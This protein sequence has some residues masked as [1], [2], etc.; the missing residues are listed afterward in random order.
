[1][2]P[3]VVISLQGPLNESDSVFAIVGK[4]E[5]TAWRTSMRACSLSTSPH[6]AQTIGV[7][8]HI[9]TILAVNALQATP[10][11]Q[12]LKIHR[13]FRSISRT[14]VKAATPFFATKY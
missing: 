8:P 9:L 3:I 4:I 11:N 2:I 12:G 13:I 14:G 10:V 1:M 6:M 5:R 7:P